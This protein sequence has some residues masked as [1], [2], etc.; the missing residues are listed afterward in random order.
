MPPAGL[1]VV[2]AA[3]GRT[4]YQRV[5]WPKAFLTLVGQ[6]HGEYLTPGHTGFDP[7][8]STMTDFL[9][10][11]LRDDGTARERLPLGDVPGITTWSGRI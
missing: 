8:M 3:R 1:T 2:P 4:A 11:V 6:G 7:T 5:R 9:R 10:W